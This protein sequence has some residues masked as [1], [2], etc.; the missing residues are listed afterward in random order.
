MTKGPSTTEETER[1][2]EKRGEDERQQTVATERQA[3]G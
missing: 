2:L 3:L 1:I